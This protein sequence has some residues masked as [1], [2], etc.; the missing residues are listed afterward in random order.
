MAFNYQKLKGRIT[1]ILGTQKNFADTLGISAVSLSR[2]L[3]NLASFSQQE[4][5]NA[6]DILDIPKSEISSYFFC[7]ES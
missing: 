3:N 2:K 6:I 5:E 4:I 1:E 7:T